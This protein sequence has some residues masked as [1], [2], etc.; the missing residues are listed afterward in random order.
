MKLVREDL[1]RLLIG[2]AFFST[3]GGGSLGAGLKLI[4]EVDEVE[5]IRVEEAKEEAYCATAFL[6]GSIESPSLEELRY[7]GAKVVVE[8]EADLVVEAFSV[9][10]KNFP[11]P[12][13]YLLP[14]ELGGHNTA[15]SLYLAFKKG[16]PLLDADLTGRSAPEM[17]QTSYWLGKIPPSPAGVFTP[18]G[19][20]FYV[21]DL[22]DYRRFDDFLRSLVELCWGADVGV[23][24]FPV[25]VEVGKPF[26]IEKSLSRSAKA[27][28]LIQK[29]KWRQAVEQEGGRVIFE[30]KVVEEVHEVMR[31]FTFGFILL[32]QNGAILELYYKNELMLA[33][34]DGQVVASAPDLIGCVDSEGMP[35]L[36]TEIKKGKEVS[37]YCLPS[38]SIWLTEEGKNIFNPHHFFSD[39]VPSFLKE[40]LKKYLTN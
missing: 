37:V 39:A 7:K 32:K 3:G 14:V 29:G 10:E 30:G 38:P 22:N 28:E 31:G 36:N 16:L 17:Y 21:E 2:A 5:V 34:L 25:K 33:V 15:V 19:E 40:K 8:K 12:I 35:L 27:G 11:Y 13:L 1:E 9:L 4:E 20:K 23:A 6:A 24:C 26:F 18:V